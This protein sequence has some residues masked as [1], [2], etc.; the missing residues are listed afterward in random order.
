V[1]RDFSQ[2]PFSERLPAKALE[3]KVATKKELDANGKKS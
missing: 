2:T 3:N 1:T